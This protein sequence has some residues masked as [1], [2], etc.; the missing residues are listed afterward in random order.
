MCAPAAALLTV[1]SGAMQAYG[2]YQE[3]KSTNAYYQYM[4][5][6]NQEQAK[7]VEK[8]GEAQS[9]LIQDTASREGKTLAEGQAKTRSSQKAA[10]A[11][12]GIVGGTPEDI[13]S[14]TLRTQFLDESALRYNAD[15]KSY[16]ATEGAKTQ[17]YGL[18]SQADQFRFAGKQA[19]KAGKIGAFTT[20]VGTAAGMFN[21]F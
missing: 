19:K 8:T 17:A 13:V 14:D 11:S 7:L 1:A 9:R 18:R 3:G 16:E 4:A 10:L 6:Q 5:N 20:L 2:K 12:A 21:P 15:V